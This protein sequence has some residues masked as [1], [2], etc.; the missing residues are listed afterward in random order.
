MILVNSSSVNNISCKQIDSF[1]YCNLPINDDWRVSTC[2]ELLSI[3]DSIINVH[4]AEGSL[5]TI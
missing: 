2:K 5:R 4:T 3:R 1:I